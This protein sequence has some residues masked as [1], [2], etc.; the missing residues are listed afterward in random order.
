MLSDSTSIDQRVESSASVL[1]NLA[2]TEVLSS[3][4]RYSL[5]VS[6]DLDNYPPVCDLSAGSPVQDGCGMSITFDATDSYDPL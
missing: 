6:G 1:P 4:F 3:Y 5:S 2:D